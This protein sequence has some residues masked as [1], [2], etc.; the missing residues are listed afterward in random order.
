VTTRQRAKCI[1]GPWFSAT[2]HNAQALMAE[3]LNDPADYYQRLGQA[4]ERQRNTARALDAYLRGLGFA[5][6]S[7]ALLAATQRLRQTLALE[8]R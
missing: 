5:P 6:D 1:L 7:P 2:T 3:T 4:Y 8:T